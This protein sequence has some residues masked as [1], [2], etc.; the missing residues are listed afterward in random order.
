M[1]VDEVGSSS[2]LRDFHAA[3]EGLREDLKGKA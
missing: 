2:V 1:T 3:I